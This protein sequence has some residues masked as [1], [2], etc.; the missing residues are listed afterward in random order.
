MTDITALLSTGPSS[1]RI[2]L[3][4][5]AEGYQTSERAKFLAD[6][7]S[8]LNYML[9]PANASLNQPFSTFRNYFNAS[10]LFVASNQSGLDTAAVTVDTYFGG[11]QHGA[12]GRLVYGDTQKVNSTV[13]GA[14]ASSAHDIT[15]VLVNSSSYGGSGGS[16]AWAT[17][18]NRSSAE[19]LLHEIG[20]SFASLED[21]YADAS[22]LASFPLSEMDSVHLST[23]QSQV[24]WAPWLGYTDSL[25][26]VGTYEGG[27]YRSTGVWRA[28]QNSKMFQFDVAFNAPEKEAFALAYY[29]SIGDYLS[30]D[31]AIPGLVKAVVPDPVLLSYAWSVNG[32]S[33]STYDRNYLDVYSLGTAATGEV[34]SLM[35]T[36]ATGIIRTGLSLTMQTENLAISGV[37]IQ[38]I[39]DQS[40][41]LPQSHV[42][43]RFG[44]ANNQIVFGSS[45]SADYVDGGAGQDTLVFDGS[46]SNYSMSVLSTGMRLFSVNGAPVLAEKNVERLQF[47]DRKIALDLSPSDHGGKAIEFIGLMAPSLIGSQSAVGTILGIFDQAK[48]MRDVCQFAIDVGL[49]SSLAGSNSNSALA[50]MVYKNLTDTQAS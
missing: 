24:P 34:V 28:T 50:A 1:H 4:F 9:D 38:D 29:N 14:Y 30:F 37:A 12:D 27:Y 8:F 44:A 25:G 39:A 26:T 48:S 40:Y 20:H 45:V 35:T 23:S 47:S 41:S 32:T 17:T 19:I 33:R 18:G 2:D 46:A 22:L 31:V 15:I 5:V 10:A 21:E 49:V 42:L 43:Y 3:V 7:D 13:S 36:D 6:A 11:G 16:E